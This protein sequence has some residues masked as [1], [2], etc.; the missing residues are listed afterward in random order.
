MKDCK[1]RQGSD[2]TGTLIVLALVVVGFIV[3]TALTDEPEN[4]AIEATGSFI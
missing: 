4:Q 1:R 2:K 3:F